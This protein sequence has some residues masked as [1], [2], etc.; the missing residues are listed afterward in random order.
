MI[1]FSS[2]CYN[3]SCTILNSLYIYI[4]KI[5]VIVPTFVRLST[6]IQEVLTCSIWGR[7]TLKDYQHFLDNGFTLEDRIDNNVYWGCSD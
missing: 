7:K 2:I 6:D 3:T 4:Y 5:A 1:I